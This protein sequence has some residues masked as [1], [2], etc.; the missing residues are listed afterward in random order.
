[1]TAIQQLSEFSGQYNGQGVN[2]ENEEFTGNL[3]VTPILNGKGI[4]IRYSATG[5]DGICFHEERTV[6][7]T[8]FSGNV[9]MW[10][11]NSNSPGMAELDLRSNNV[12]GL[13]FGIGDFND[14]D[15]FR[16]EIKI[17]LKNKSIGYHY[18]WGLPGGEFE[19]RSGL[20]MKKV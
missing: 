19:Y 15:T 3:K 18:S 13:T 8:D 9:K 12:E 17:E 6:I 7:S 20:M 14:V 11:L 2:H 1:M 5:V 10:N 16:E 4:E